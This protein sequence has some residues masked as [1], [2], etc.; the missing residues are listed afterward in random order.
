MNLGD[1]NSLSSVAS[2][3]TERPGRYGKQLVSH[4][5]RRWGGDWSADTESGWI[6]LGETGRAEITAETDTLVMQ[7]F[8]PDAET[9]TRLEGA[10]GRHL[11]RFGAKDELTV[12]WTRDDDIPGTQQRWDDP[13]PEHD[14]EHRPGGPS[15]S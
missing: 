14:R 13:E 5:S 15:V 3:T 2:V 9:I 7:V 11:V 12:A 10:V 8:A 6:Q 1:P 4:M